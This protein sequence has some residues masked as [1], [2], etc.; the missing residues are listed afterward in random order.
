[1]GEVKANGRG[2]A[3]KGDRNCCEHLVERGEPC[4]RGTDNKRTT[5][6]VSISPLNRAKMAQK[7]AA[8]R[9]RKGEKNRG[10]LK[11]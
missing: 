9:G 4:N 1:M 8:S 10:A 5:A 7:S 3:S 11:D 2:R 6:T